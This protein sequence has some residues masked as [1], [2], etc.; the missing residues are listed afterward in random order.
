MLFQLSTLR[1]FKVATSKFKM[2]KKLASVL[3]IPFS[4]F[5]EIKNGNTFK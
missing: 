4:F 5:S 1:K 3:F 2:V